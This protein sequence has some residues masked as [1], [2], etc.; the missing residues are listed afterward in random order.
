MAAPHVAGVAALWWEQVLASP[1]P[2][3]TATAVVVANLLASA[4]PEGFVPDVDP[5]DRGVGL[6]QA[7]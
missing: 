7:P 1:V 3:A 4:T 5:V 6:V 2:P